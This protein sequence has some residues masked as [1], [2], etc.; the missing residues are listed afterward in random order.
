MN[1]SSIRR[2]TYLVLFIILSL[3]PRIEAGTKILNDYLQFSSVLCDP[4]DCKK[5]GFPVHQ[6]LLELTQ[7]HAR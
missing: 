3:S 5:P 4:V 7:I 6:Q 2:V 1:V